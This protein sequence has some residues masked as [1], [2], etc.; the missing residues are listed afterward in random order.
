MHREAPK[1]SAARMPSYP[2]RLTG[3]SQRIVLF[4]VVGGFL[5]GG[6]AAGY[7]GIRHLRSYLQMGKEPEQITAAQA[8]EIP[9]DSGSHWVR[10][11]EKLQLNCEQALQEISSETVEFTEYL[12]QDNGQHTFFLQYKGDTDCKAASERPLEGLLA[13]PPIYWWTKNKMPVPNP[14]SVELKVGYAPTEELHESIGA[15][16]AALV[17]LGLVAAATAR[18]SKMKAEAAHRALYGGIAVP[19]SL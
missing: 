14:Q 11:S 18:I 3:T 17:M 5:I 15:F 9:L 12:A 2:P 1:H 7:F 19:R 16:L 4:I 6:L 10:L 8:F 13:A